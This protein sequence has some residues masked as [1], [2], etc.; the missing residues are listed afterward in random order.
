M[1]IIKLIKC[2]PIVGM[3]A[4]T[5]VLSSCGDG[6]SKKAKEF[7][8]KVSDFVTQQQIDSVRA[9]YPSMEFDSIRFIKPV[10]EITVKEIQVGRPIKVDM[11]NGAWITLETSDNG[12]IISQS[13]GL[14][15][16]PAEQM[17]FATATGMWDEETTDNMLAGRLKDDNFVEWLKDKTYE[18]YGGNVEMILGEKKKK[19]SPYHEGLDIT[20]PVTVK[21]NGS[22][23]IDGKTYKIVYT[24]RYARSSDG[25][26]PDGYRNLKMDG[27]DLLPGE[28]KEIVIKREASEDIADP[29]LEFNVSRED[30]FKENFKPTGS[31]FNEYKNS[32]K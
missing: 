6:E 19:T 24:E 12:F 22:T 8:A 31:E 3:F 27:V 26:A 2:F 32:V 16:F 9:Y 10:G 1:K 30:C 5:I 29:R 7:A 23:P 18:A 20:Y 21:N 17:E 25:S 4:L 11:G 13:H 14:G 28:S 15:A